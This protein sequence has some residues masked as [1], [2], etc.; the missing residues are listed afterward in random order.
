VITAPTC[1][2]EVEPAV[3]GRS[4]AA[5]YGLGVGDPSAIKEVLA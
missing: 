4:A 1:G 2:G 5:R 3:L